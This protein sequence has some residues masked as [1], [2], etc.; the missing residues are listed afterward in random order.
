MKGSAVG[1]NNKVT[2]TLKVTNTLK[3]A[4]TLKVGITQHAY[5]SHEEGHVDLVEVFLGCPEGLVVLGATERP[6]A[7]THILRLTLG[8]RFNDQLINQ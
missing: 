4:K 5:F 8:C 2:K 7:T 3:V 6:N 1:N